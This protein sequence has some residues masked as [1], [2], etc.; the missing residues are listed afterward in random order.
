MS[1][2]APDFP[3]HLEWLNTARPLR[4]AELKGKVVLLDFWTYCC[5]NC[6]HIIPDLKRLE[7]EFGERL[8][9]IGVHSA[10]FTE[11]GQ[12]EN[13][14]QA[15]R[16]YGITHPVVNDN[17]FL[18][19]EA[20]GVRAWPTVVLIDPQGYVVMQA[21]GE[22]VYARFVEPIRR[23]ISSQ[24]GEPSL[25]VN[26]GP[27]ESAQDPGEILAFP[28][29]VAVSPD[30]EV[31]YISDQNHNRILSVERVS[32]IIREIIGSGEEGFRDGD[33]EE[34]AFRHP[35]GV[36]ATSE[37]L[38]IADT[39]NHSIRVVD[40]KRKSVSTLC[41]TGEKLHF[42]PPPGSSSSFNRLASPWD[43]CLSP[44]GDV[45]YVAMA[46]LHQIWAIDLESGRA[47]PLA[48]SGW[49]GKGDGER[50]RASLAQPSGLVYLK[51]RL[52]FVDSE[53]S[54]V[55]FVD[56]S[57]GGKVGTLVGLDLFE[58]GDRDGRGEE[59]RLQ[60]PL[61]IA[62]DGEFLYLADTYN[63]KVKRLNPHTAECITLAGTGKPGGKD[64]PLSEAQFWEPGGLVVY[65]S[66]LYIADTN[67]HRIRVI[68]LSTRQVSTL[69]L[70][71]AIP[72]SLS[73][74][75]H[76]P[77]F[78][79]AGEVGVHFT[80]LLPAGYQLN[81]EAPVEVRVVEG[82]ELISPQR[83]EGLTIKEGVIRFKKLFSVRRGRGPVAWEVSYQF[84]RKGEES[85][86]YPGRA[87]VRSF[88]TVGES[89]SG[90]RQELN[91]TV[92]W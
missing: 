51:G 40:L 65:G 64:G 36:F 91:L 82:E 73:V 5:I 41:G 23:L 15:V 12:L 16:R 54:A 37:H 34:A 79:G 25:V 90:S 9:V 14:R 92:S 67:N 6:M 63:N 50:A 22:G 70:S 78:L 24:S 49:E 46:G 30:G 60:H 18:I 75:H 21:S 77:I 80:F 84:C 74:I 13:I 33:W 76:P 27:I 29:K 42:A 35:Q 86:C 88:L 17:R 59:V 58:F 57:P 87:R 2:K 56:L 4:L 11:E 66:L 72:P 68:D 62:T 89:P 1:M 45:L 39:E 8:V 28:G 55:R 44:E 7:E 43:L 52:Y 32:G 48:G 69:T 47:Q 26:P 81:S 19:W 61:G 83:T 85:L 3:L 53:A 38:Y 71:Y 31:L 10:K 20:Y